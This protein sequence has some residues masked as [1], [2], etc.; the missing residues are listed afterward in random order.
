[1]KISRNGIGSVAS[2]LAMAL[3]AVPMA[4]PAMAADV[5]TKTNGSS[6]SGN[7]CAGKKKC[8]KGDADNPCA[9]SKCRKKDDN[10]CAGK[11]K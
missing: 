2:A 5:Q 9:G 7:P 8:S 11:S 6:C 1:M 10:P 4:P 3:M